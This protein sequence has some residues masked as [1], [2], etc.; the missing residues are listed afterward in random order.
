[1]IFGTATIGWLPKNIRLFFEKVP[2]FCWALLPKTPDNLGS[3]HVLSK[4]AQAGVSSLAH[5]R[6]PARSLV[7]PRALARSS[8]RKRERERTQ[9]RYYT[10]HTESHTTQSRTNLETAHTHTHTPTLTPTHTQSCTHTRALSHQGSLARTR[11][12]KSC[13]SRVWNRARALRAL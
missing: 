1:M 10:E 8:S 13:H 5:A 3:L 2:D 12:N 11:Y 9:W 6:A 7:F 4:R